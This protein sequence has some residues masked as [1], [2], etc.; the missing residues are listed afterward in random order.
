MIAMA[1]TPTVLIVDDEL[2]PRESLRF[3]LKNR[4]TVHCADNVDK[5]LALFKEHDPDLVILD[6]RMPGK[7]GIEGLREIRELDPKVSVVMLTGF[8]AL[9]TAQEAMR[10]GATDYISKPFDTSDMMNVVSTYTQRT[11]VERKRDS[12]L[13]E[14]RGMNEKLMG[15]LAERER[16]AAV[17]ESTVGFAHDLRNPLTIV[18]GYVDL[19]SRRIEESRGTT[20]QDYGNA[21]DYLDVIEQNVRRCCDL[22]EMWAKST[23][24]CAPEFAPTLVS[25][26]MKD[27]AMTVEPLASTHDVAIDYRVDAESGLRI[28]A[29]APQLIRALHNV[30]FNSIQAVDPGVGKVRVVCEAPGDGEVEFRIEDNGAGMSPEILARIFEPYFT[31]KQSKD[32]TGL[33]LAITMKIVEEHGGTLDVQSMPGMGTTVVIRIPRSSKDVPRHSDADAAAPAAEASC[34]PA[35]P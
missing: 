16:I 31:T 5:G 3:L 32:G 17:N 13:G 4:Y 2:G 14:L 30:I 34:S 25:Q 8:G 22:S 20:G 29:T 19:L 27:L 7:S 26:V 12:M 28:T 1:N 9:E 18:S 10:F 6:I 23:R 24:N 21:L 33:G 35:V 15:D 11:R